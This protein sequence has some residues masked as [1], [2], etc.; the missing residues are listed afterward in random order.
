MKKIALLCLFALPL[1]AGADVTF[2]EHVQPE[3]ESMPGQGQ[4]HDITFEIKGDKV[5]IDGVNG[6]LSAI[7]DT[8]TGDTIAL[9][10]KMKVFVK[11]PLDTLKGV[12]SQINGAN[13]SNAAR[14]GGEAPKITDTGRQEK[15]G[16]YDAEVYV[17]DTPRAKTT[18]WVSNKVAGCATIQAATA[19]FVGLLAKLGVPNLPD[20]SKIDGVPVKTEIM[21]V[22][23]KVTIT[24][25]SAK[26]D[27]ILDADLQA[28]SDYSE[29]TINDLQNGKFM[30]MMQQSGVGS[31]SSSTTQPGAASP[32]PLSPA[33][34]SGSAAPA[35]PPLELRQ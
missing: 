28:P 32:V 4:G 8:G 26:E 34:G 31:S 33:S 19:K 6:K 17:V 18:L 22:N 21:S 1:R 2:V 20:I 5:R 13:S 30:Q 14:P 16:D 25:L 10:H 7:F 15:V 3:V 11:A 12:V 23:N 35:A 29:V 24:L 9:V 27:P